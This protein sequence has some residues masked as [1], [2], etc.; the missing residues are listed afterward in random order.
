MNKKF[1]TKEDVLNEIYKIRGLGCER[2]YPRHIFIDNKKL[3]GFVEYFV[4][5]K[6]TGHCNE[7]GY[8]KA[9]AKKVIT[10]KED[11]LNYLKY[12]Y[13]LYDEMKLINK[14]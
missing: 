13:N 14:D 4:S 10:N 1:K 6:C 3:D 8:C 2:K 12:L 11:I 5:N 7:C 9:I